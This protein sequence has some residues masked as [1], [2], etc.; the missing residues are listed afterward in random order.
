MT[1]LSKWWAGPISNL[2]DFY[3]TDIK[4]GLS[5][6]QVL[7]NAERFGK[8]TFAE[9]KPASAFSF[10]IEGIKSPMMLLLLSIAVLSLIFSKFLEAAIMVLSSWLMFS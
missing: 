5:E 4:A 8:N 2:A 6:T 1:D 9:L 10:L 3:D 7:K